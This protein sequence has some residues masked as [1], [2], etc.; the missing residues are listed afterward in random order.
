MLLLL[1]AT[2]LIFTIRPRAI[3]KIHFTVRVQLGYLSAAHCAGEL[4]CLAQNI[5]EGFPPTHT[6]ELLRAAVMS[7]LTAS[8]TASGFFFCRPKKT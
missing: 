3:L 2:T 4:V 5:I 1:C 7:F 8:L 6:T